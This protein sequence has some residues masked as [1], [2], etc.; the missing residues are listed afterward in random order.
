MNDQPDH[1]PASTNIGRDQINVQ[2]SPGFV[3]RAE[4]VNQTFNVAP[5][6]IPACPAPNATELFGRAAMIDELARRLI[7]GQGA[8]AICAVRGLPGVGK[9]DLLRAT[10]R[11]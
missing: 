5:P 4:T 6:R 1:Q 7:E 10:G 8:V 9:T 2:G 3:N 11:D